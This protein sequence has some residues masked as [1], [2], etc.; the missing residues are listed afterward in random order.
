[1]A[2]VA[3]PDTLLEDLEN[4]RQQSFSKIFRD[5]TVPGPNSDSCRDPIRPVE[6]DITARQDNSIELLEH[7]SGSFG[8]KDNPINFEDH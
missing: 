4:T 8:M 7:D 1:M 5:P 6:L 2:A 3:A